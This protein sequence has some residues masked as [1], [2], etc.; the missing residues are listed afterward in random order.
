MGAASR[1]VVVGA[2][3]REAGL[4]LSL[5]ALLWFVS[6]TGVICTDGT[7]STMETGLWWPWACIGGGVGGFGD[8]A[9]DDK[10]DVVDN[11]SGLGGFGVLLVGGGCGGS[12][13]APPEM[14]S[15]RTG[16]SLAS[17]NALR[18]S[19][20]ARFFLNAVSIRLFISSGNWFRMRA[21]AMSFC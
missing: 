6:A 14:I 15:L 8:G 21:S 7:S 19:S 18:L 16:T 11:V 1:G 4:S 9:G 10:E 2:A 13:G 12:A 5:M 3:S 20:S 17:S